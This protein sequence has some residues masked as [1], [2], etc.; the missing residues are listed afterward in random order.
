MYRTTHLQDRRDEEALEYGQ[1]R[2]PAAESYLH[3]R[4]N[5]WPRLARS[6]SC[7]RNP[8]RAQVLGADRRE[9]GVGVGRGDTI[10]PYI[11]GAGIG[12]RASWMESAQYDWND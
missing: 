12:R 11:V 8:R 10:R 2:S 6:G 4:S 1:H 9:G 3:R 7:E 5:E